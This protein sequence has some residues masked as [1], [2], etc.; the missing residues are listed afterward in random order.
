MLLRVR[1]LLFSAYFFIWT[2]IIL[3]TIWVFLPFSRAG[4]LN[5]LSYWGR[6][7]RFG[8]K[9]IVGLDYEIRGREYIPDHAAIV[10]C[11]HQ[12]VWETMLFHGLLPNPVFVFKKELMAIPLW[13]AY[14]RK[15][16]TIVID[17]SAGTSA[18]KGMVREAAQNFELGRSLVLFPEGT[19]R[20]PGD[21]PAYRRGIVAVYA[22]CGVPVVP[23]ALNSGFFWGPHSLMK[24]P[25]TIVAEFLPP[26]EP[27]LD[28]KTFMKEL[29]TRIET[30]S[31]RLFEEAEQAK[32]LR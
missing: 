14:A 17:R 18:L 9:W 20:A 27:G 10:A 16:D 6:G 13:G 12:S 11:K 30:A 7:N 15:V 23:V 22:Q 19:R 2:V 5:A 25:G 1:S 4:M 3:L 21:P 24:L 32:L 29:E 31:N 28:R 8:L 26:I